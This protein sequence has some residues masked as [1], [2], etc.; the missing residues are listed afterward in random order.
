MAKKKVIL[1]PILH[2]QMT[3]D[4]P[5]IQMLIREAAKRKNVVIDCFAGGG[6]TSKGFK[7]HPD[8][9]VIACV[10]HW[11]KAILSHFANFPNCLH[12][13]EDFRTANLDLIDY[14][15]EEVRKINPFIKVHTWFSYECTN[16]S[17]A[18]GGLPRDA[19]S[20][21]LAEDG[22]RYIRTL[23]PDHIWIEN[24]KE[25]MLWG[26]MIPKVQSVR[27]GK[28]H[29]VIVPKN[30]S[31]QEELKYYDLLIQ[32]GHVLVCP[33][34]KDKKTQTLEKWLIP[35]PHH[36]GE[37]YDKWV[38]ETKALGYD[39]HY[40]HINCAN[41]GCPTT[42]T[43]LFIQFPRVG[44]PV[45]WPKNS[46]DKRGANGLPKWKP[47]KDCLDLND[48]GESALKSWVNKKGELK[49]RITSDKSVDRLIGGTIK[50]AL[51][52]DGTWLIKY[53]SA[54]NNTSINLGASISE[55]APTIPAR[56]GVALAHAQFLNQAF[57]GDPATKSTSIEDPSRTL[58]AKGGNLSITDVQFLN[59]V[60][61]NGFS[62]PLEKPNPTARTKDC[63]NLITAQFINEEYSTSK[64]G[65]SIY[66]PAGSLLGK[67]KQK[68][69]EVDRVW[70]EDSQYNNGGFDIN[71]PA[72][73][74][75]ADRRHFYIISYQFNSKGRDIKQP[76]ETLLASMDSKP[77]YL[78]VVETGE[79]AIE[80]YDTDP[81][82]IRKLKSF[83]AYYGIV[84]IK[85]RML[86]IVELKRITTLPDD[87]ILIG[88]QEDQKKMI[89]NAVPSKA[90]YEMAAAYAE[91]WD[92][93][94]LQKAA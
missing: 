84:D 1:N 32:N 8:Y 69:I 23:N 67:P 80:V 72:R 70:I 57:S 27:N 56:G 52:G 65:K 78:V 4:D 35:D 24:V 66:D 48:I 88:S 73:T 28:K 45:F 85:M 54:K 64:T 94:Y 7:D 90:V 19:D 12:L 43:R 21:T 83:M 26:P 20:R 13:E 29:K 47:V 38:T 86:K 33:L 91:G 36:K 87:Y 75:T 93:F 63:H 17:F 3:K 92:D 79:I 61:G 5:F 34:V 11:H 60:Y 51:N 15:I 76:A 25:F 44:D 30:S 37:D 6:G 10:N 14:M 31:E 74:I 59:H 42:R 81:A 39:Y 9:F 89:G 16:F 22:I 41:V 2:S 77:P 18:K 62:T 58:T 50:H 68:L 82:H 46:Y 40:K 71:G 55:P 49:W 53:Y